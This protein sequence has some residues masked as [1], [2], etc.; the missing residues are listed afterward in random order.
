M[1]YSSL[2]PL[3]ER[4]R[5]MACWQTR[6]VPDKNGFGLA[7]VPKVTAD[8]MG[9]AA[10]IAESMQKRLV[11]CECFQGECNMCGYKRE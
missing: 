6:Q 10:L 9:T 2:K 8:L 1:K 5:I 3:F 4:V 7:W 11:C